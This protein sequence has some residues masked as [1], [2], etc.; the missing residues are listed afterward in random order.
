VEV[1]EL[2][3][4]C[5]ASRDGAFQIDFIETQGG[6]RG[7]GCQARRDGAFQIVFKESNGG[8]VAVSTGHGCDERPIIA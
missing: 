1:D 6:E 4:R 3:E 2:S 7:E 5:H 8:N